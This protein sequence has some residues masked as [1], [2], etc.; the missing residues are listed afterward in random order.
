MKPVNDKNSNISKLSWGIRFNK[1]LP[2]KYPAKI[3]RITVGILSNLK[4]E[5]SMGTNQ[6]MATITNSGANGISK[7]I[8]KNINFRAA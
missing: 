1:Y 2:I 3:S 5:D 8:L 6:A 7:L 4:R